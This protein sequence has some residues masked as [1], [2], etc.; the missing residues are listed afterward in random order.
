MKDTDYRRLQFLATIAILVLVITSIFAAS[1]PVT[2]QTTN[3]TR[4]TIQVSGG[5]T[6]SATPDQTILRI[7][8][9]TQST[10]ASQASQDNAATMANVMQALLTVGLSTDSIKTSSFSL[11]PIYDNTQKTPPRLV[12]YSVTN[13]IQATL[14]NTGSTGKVIDA[15]IAAGASQINEVTFTLTSQTLATLQ[16]QAYQLAV[17]D[18]DG[19]AQ[20]IASSLG[21]R[22]V[23]PI[24]ITTGYS[25]Q[26]SVTRLS[27]Y[28]QTPIQPG[29]LQVSANIQVTYEV[30]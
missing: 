3:F 8:V 6:I 17:K 29:T 27:A 14:S 4:K 7:A 2:V 21:L 23:G 26:P 28:V 22:V 11:A 24:I 10:T 5:G 18:A 20:A 9:V 15:A 16:K 19:Q 1:R 25:S 12:G 30:T 13:E